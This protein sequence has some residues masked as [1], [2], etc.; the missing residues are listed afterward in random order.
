MVKKD[1]DASFED[2]QFD[3]SEVEPESFKVCSLGRHRIRIDKA[4]C[5][6]SSK[7]EPMIRLTAIVED[8]EDSEDNGAY[9]FDYL[10]WNPDNFGRIATRIAACGYDSKKLKA[11]MQ[12]LAAMMVG[13]EANVS[14]KH[15]QFEGENRAKIGRWIVPQED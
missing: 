11:N 1:Q 8:G 13:W 3:G 10:V 2:L 5:T 9:L 7:Q 15:E 4:D 6:I 12:E 14:V